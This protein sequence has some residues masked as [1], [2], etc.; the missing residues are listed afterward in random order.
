M[1]D[2]EILQDRFG[3]E[4][5]F[6]QAGE[7]TFGDES[8]YGLKRELP[9]KKTSVVSDFYIGIHPVTQT[10]WENVMGTNPSKFKDDFFDGLNP[11]ESVTWDD[12]QDFLR[13]INL[14][15][16]LISETKGKWRLPTEIEWEYVAKAGTSSRWSFGNSDKD[17]DE[18]GWH[19]G[20]SGGRPKYVGQKKPNLWGIHDMYGNIAEWCQSDWTKDHNTGPASDNTLKVHKGGTWYTESDSTRSSARGKGEKDRQYD[21]VGMRLVWESRL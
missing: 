17:L 11:V 20:N 9:S 7:F 18:H 2:D 15:A 8:G 14:V 6:I 16:P 13:E 21:G 12:C 10:L 19:A 3:N 5:R 1:A 4:Y